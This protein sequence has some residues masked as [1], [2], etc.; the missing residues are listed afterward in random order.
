MGLYYCG[1]FGGDGIKFVCVEE[2]QMTVVRFS[3]RE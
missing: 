1:G 2:G 3:P